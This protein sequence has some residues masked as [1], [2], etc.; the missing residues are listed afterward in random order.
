VALAHRHEVRIRYGEVDMQRVVFN[1]HYLAYC[2]DASD[3]WL[4][5][6]GMSATSEWDVMVKRAD[7]T[8]LGGAT[9][10]EVLV[11]DLS[12][13]R[14]GNTSFDV[15]FDGHVD[16]RPVFDAV[17]TYV[18]VKMGTLEPVRVPDVLRALGPA[19]VANT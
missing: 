18:V 16:D 11:L 2:D 9:V 15:A 10:G 13:A 7:I 4:R 14:V 8:W 1:A 12:V 5:S 3:I 19:D 6:L 17:L